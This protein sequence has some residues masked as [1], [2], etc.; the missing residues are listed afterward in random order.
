MKWIA[1]L[2][3]GTIML[4]A[5]VSLWIDLSGD[6]SW[7]L[8]HASFTVLALTLVA[9]ILYTLTNQQIAA[10]TAAR[11]KRESVLSTM[12]YM[13]MADP[14]PATQNVRVLFGFHNPST[15]IVFAKVWCNLKVYGAS[16]D[17]HPDFKGDNAWQ[18]FPQQLAQG[19]FGID[20]V[21]DQHGKS[22]A[23]MTAETKPE[24][25]ARQLTMELVVEF[26]DQLGSV[27]KLP[28]RPHFFDFSEWRWVPQFTKREEW[29]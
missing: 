2:I 28:A 26:R 22:V 8:E 5:L 19:W 14:D 6:H 7:G 12:Y 9:L 10:T 16:A 11:W 29:T 3:S 23:Q 4:G 24:N 15:L 17:Y 21:L 27:R 13:R 25:R 1:I 20:K 18:L